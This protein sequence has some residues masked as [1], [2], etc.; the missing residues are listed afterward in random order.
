MDVRE[1][2]W[3][4]KKKRMNKMKNKGLGKLILK[5]YFFCQDQKC[6]IENILNP[7]QNFKTKQMEKR[8]RYFLPN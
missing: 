8:F 7:K 4:C 6:A 5:D 1:K 3:L 2:I